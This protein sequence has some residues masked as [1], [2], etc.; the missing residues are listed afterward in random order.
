MVF[1]PTLLKN[2]SQVK[3][4]HLPRVK[5]I[6]LFETTTQKNCLKGWDDDSKARHD[7]IRRKLSKGIISIIIVIIII[8]ILNNLLE[9]VSRH[10]TFEQ[11]TGKV[12]PFQFP[13]KN[14]LIAHS[15]VENKAL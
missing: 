7:F 6:K 8:M 3:L 9:A 12:L 4:D 10:Q 13:R 14:S 2:I 1:S 5:N 15:S 11:Q